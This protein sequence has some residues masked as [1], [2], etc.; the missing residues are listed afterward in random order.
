MGWREHEDFPGSTEP[1]GAE[2]L[3]PG[4]TKVLDAVSYIVCARSSTDRASDYGSEG[5]G[6]ESLRARPAQR[7]VPI[8]EP[9][10][11]MS[12]TAAEYS[13]ADR[14][15]GSCSGLVA[16]VEPVA[17]PPERVPCHLV[18][19]LS[20]D[21]HRERDPAVPEDGHRDARVDVERGQERAAGT[22][23]VVERDAADAVASA[24]DI[25]SSAA[26]ASAT[27]THTRS[28]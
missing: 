16:L 9:A 18:G 8:L 14:N 5:W 20:V 23:G 24:P 25:E 2:S 17:Q 7:P 3:N 1:S 13:N 10:F 27:S 21:F 15:G 28:P 26:L 12:G 22:A 11:C 6:F 4:T 19:N